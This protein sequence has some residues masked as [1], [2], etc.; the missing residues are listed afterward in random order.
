MKMAVIKCLLRVNQ[1]GN[2]NILHLPKAGPDALPVSEVPILRMIN[3]VAEGGAEDCCITNVQQVNVLDVDRM[4]EIER[5]K[6]KYGPALVDACYPGGRGLPSTV[7]D[8]ELPSS[9]IA[10][11]IKKE[12]A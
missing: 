6:S 9:S 1:D 2:P 12:V 3:D 11:R 7:E 5:L 4:P 10:K 8:C